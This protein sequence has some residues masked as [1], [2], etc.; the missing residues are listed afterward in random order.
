MIRES[1]AKLSTNSGSMSSVA[2]PMCTSPAAYASRIC[3]G[4][5]IRTSSTL[6]GLPPGACQSLPGL[7]PLL[8][9]MIGAQPAQ[10]LRANRT[11]SSCSGL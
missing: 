4:S 6:N 2:Q 3:T 5:S 8:A 10:T 11:V 7:K 1:L 9:R